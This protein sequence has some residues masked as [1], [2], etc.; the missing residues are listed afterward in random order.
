MT[1][2]GPSKKVSPLPRRDGRSDADETSRQR[3]SR[4]RVSAITSGTN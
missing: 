4:A 2:N 1:V 3:K